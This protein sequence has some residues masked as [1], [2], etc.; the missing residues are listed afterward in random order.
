MICRNLLGAQFLLVDNFTKRLSAINLLEDST[1]NSIPA[2]LPVMIFASFQKEET[3]NNINDINIQ[4]DLN[5][6]IL[7]SIVVR[8]DFNPSPVSKSISN[9][10]VLISEP[11][12]L[13]ISVI[14]N[15]KVLAR[16]S[17]NI[18]SSSNRIG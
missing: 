16:Y 10:G 3:D 8:V 18:N 17:V 9:S 12:V 11:G 15:Q 6:K 4:I 1:V 2:I 13:T 14:F 5:G 7:T